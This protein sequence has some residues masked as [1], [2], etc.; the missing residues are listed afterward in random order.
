MEERIYVPNNKKLKEKIL[1]G[2]YDSVDV[3]HSGQQQILELI[4]RN[5]W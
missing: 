4:K 3:G 2:N 5:Y 1:Q